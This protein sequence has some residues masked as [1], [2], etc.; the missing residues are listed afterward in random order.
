[1][2][3]ACQEKQRWCRSWRRVAG[4]VDN[5]GV[6]DRVDRP[7]PIEFLDVGPAG[8]PRS[9]RRQSS[10]LWRFGAG[11]LVAA[12]VT[13]AVA[14]H[15]GRAAHK[16]R[17][18]VA[19]VSR[20]APSP[21]PSVPSSAAAP[22]RTVTRVG[23][24]VLPGVHGWQLL[25]LSATGV[26]RM[27]PR[28][29]QL[30]TTPLPPLRSSGPVS[31]LAVAGE[32]LVR[33]IDV[34]PGYV[35]PDAGPARP[36]PERLAASGPVLPGP[37]A[38]H[39]WVQSTGSAALELV[40]LD[41][42]RTGARIGRLPAGDSVLDA[43]ADGR[44]NLLFPT[45]RGFYDLRPDGAHLVTTGSLVA[46]GPGRWLVRECASRRRCALTSIDA[47]GHR[48]VIRAGPPAGAPY[49]AVSPTGRFAAL[50][51]VG[52]TGRLSLSVLDV[53]T[54]VVHPV[55]TPP[56]QSPGDTLAWSP[57]GRWLLMVDSA[58]HVDAVTPWTGG[59]LRLPRLAGVTQLVVRG[60]VP[61]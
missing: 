61:G 13:V 58:G 53:G 34:V 6:D 1:M 56:S 50:Y 5:R 33:P 51:T 29:G 54:G 10:L 16:G 37:D 35:V 28:S 18:A 19:A 12:G 14:G 9:R 48:H 3:C 15:S 55:A 21:V 7:D 32:A 43:V 11:A 22:A 8:E 52:R 41:G 60:D 47:A 27:D 4:A 49:G 39:V 38:R 2:N 20:R 42:H 40:A 45:P 26:G 57:D 36:M 24:P 25:T 31:F 17:A 23:H 44:G 30:V 46:L 59:V